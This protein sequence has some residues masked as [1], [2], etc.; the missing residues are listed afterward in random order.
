MCH[1][2][3]Q[4]NTCTTC[5]QQYGPTDEKEVKCAEAIEND[6]PWGGCGKDEGWWDIPSTEVGIC[7]PC[8]EEE[9]AKREAEDCIFV[10]GED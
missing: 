3:K 2:T 9:I 10:G 5:H 8:M 4:N 6:L 7:E 1:R